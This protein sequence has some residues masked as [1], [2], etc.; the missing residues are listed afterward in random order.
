[1]NVHFYQEIKDMRLD[2]KFILPP[3]FLNIESQNTMGLFMGHSMILLWAMRI[4]CFGQVK[5]R[6]ESPTGSELSAGARKKKA[7]VFGWLQSNGRA[8]LFLA[9]SGSQTLQCPFLSL[10]VKANLFFTQP[11]L[12]F[13]LNNPRSMQGSLPA[14]FYHE[15]HLR[16]QFLKS[17]R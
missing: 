8:F 5:C 9:P 3:N 12:N 15:L 7:E 10:Q 11:D 2:I 14:T 17:V 1:M 16:Q 6:L 4:S 13:F